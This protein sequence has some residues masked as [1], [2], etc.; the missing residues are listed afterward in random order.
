MAFQLKSETLRAAGNTALA[1]AK[2]ISERAGA[3]GRQMTPAEQA[4]HDAAIAQGYQIVDQMKAAK[5][6]E[7]I[8]AKARAMADEI[9]DINGTGT[10]N[11]GGAQVK[12]RDWA[13][14]T[15]DKMTA[16]AEQFGVK[17]LVTGS[18]DVANPISAGVVPMPDNPT[19]L[20]DLIVQREPLSGNAFSYL[21]Q[22]VRTNN[23][24]PVA[25][26]ALKPTSVFTYA[27]ID[28]KAHVIAHLSQP[29]P[30][31]YLADHSAL[32]SLLSSE[33]FRGVNQAVEA[34]VI[35]GTGVGENMTGILAAAGTVA[36][37]YAT[38]V[39]ATLRKARTALATREEV[40]TAWA[41]SLADAEL[42]DLSMD[43]QGRFYGS[44][45]D[46]VVFGNLPKIVIPGI[47][48]GVAVL[49]DWTQCKL[50]VR[51]DVKLDAD[52]SGAN[53]TNNSVVLRAEGRYGFGVLRPQ[54]FAIVDL[55]AGV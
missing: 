20:I 49:A 28:D 14:K 42:F 17:A 7:S 43:N 33:M 55:T 29:I 39:F 30:E 1:E 11:R 38:S 15:A 48:A 37:P 45:V 2:S 6:D 24:A 52:R 19:R 23:A 47:P 44:D 40:P 16:A 27:E 31:R 51:E 8:L 32:E 53:F 41:F 36:V 13:A 26:L 3:A 54:A 22:T 46:D 34:Q 12:A 25:D 21:R 4:A 18:I 50:F 9:G 10:G 5:A 35:S